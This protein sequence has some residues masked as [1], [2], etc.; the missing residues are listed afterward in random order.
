MSETIDLEQ[1]EVLVT[2]E[3]V[4]AT[5]QA[6]LEYAEMK[7]HES[8]APWSTIPLDLRIY[9]NALP[10]NLKSSLVTVFAPGANTKIERHPNAT[11]IVRVMAGQCD[12]Q[13][14][15][16]GPWQSNLK[17]SDAPELENRWSVVA[18]GV[19]HCPVQ[20]GDSGWSVL[21]FHTVPA[22]DLIDERA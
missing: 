1:L 4:R 6:T 16:D 20:T 18:P 22:D 8:N 9:G 7:R 19:W 10:D 13:T 21:A 3:D 14:R 11:Q 17:A 15:T 12:I 5:I 2:R